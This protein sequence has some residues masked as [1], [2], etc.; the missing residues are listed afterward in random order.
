MGIKRRLIRSIV[1]HPGYVIFLSLAVVAIVSV[2]LG[3]IGTQEAVATGGQCSS[4]NV[5]LAD[6]LQILKVLP[7]ILGIG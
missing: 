2:A 6:N 7:G 1:A 3:T 4:C 5:H